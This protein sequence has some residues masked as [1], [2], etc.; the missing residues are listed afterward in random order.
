M[1]IYK[2]CNA[3]NKNYSTQSLQ[4]VCHEYFKDLHS[5]IYLTNHRTELIHNANLVLF[6]LIT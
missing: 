2:H 5:N 4:S 1:S 6:Y 3:C